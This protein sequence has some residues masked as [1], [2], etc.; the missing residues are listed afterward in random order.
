MNVN[1]NGKEQHTYDAIVVGSGISGGWAAKELCEAGLKVLM[2][3][4]GKPVEHPNYPTATLDPWQIPYRGRLTTEDKRVKHIQARHW[5]FQQDN[6]H[7]YI[8]DLENP[9][10]ETKRFDWVRAD[11]V[12]GRSLLWSRQCL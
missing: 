11:V 12:G 1:Q 2:L 3:E 8:N 6:Q 4:R 7:F 5:S 10:T 9:Y